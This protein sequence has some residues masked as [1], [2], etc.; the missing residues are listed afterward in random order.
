MKTIVLFC[1]LIANFTDVLKQVPR[2]QNVARAIPHPAD[3][4][5]THGSTA[6]ILG[7]IHTNQTLLDNSLNISDLK[8]T[9][10]PS[11]EDLDLSH[12]SDGNRLKL[13]SMLRKYESMWDRSLGEI[14]KVRHHIELQGDSRPMMQPLYKC[15]PHSRKFL[16]EEVEKN[17]V[18]PGYLTR[19]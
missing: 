19:S 10:I 1:I 7:L 4:V 11:I 2:N 14:N 12:I 3:T 9:K 5:P 13:T 18:P 16:S 15:R 6:D 17:V 8:T